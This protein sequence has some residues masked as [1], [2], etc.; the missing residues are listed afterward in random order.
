MDVISLYQSGFTNA[1]ASL[2]TA[3]TPEQAGIIKKY[4]GK[5]VLCYDADEAG[6]KAALRAGGI[7][8]EAGIKTKVL[9]ITDGKDPD[10]YIKAK[11]AE[12]F[13]NLIEKAKNLTEYRILKI[14]KEYNLEDSAEK[15]EFIT[16]VA[17]VFSAIKDPVEREIFMK[18]FSRKYDIS[19]DAVNVHIKRHTQK[20]E[21]A[22]KRRVEKTERKNFEARTGGRKSVDGMRLYNAEQLVLNLMCEKEV[23]S[24]IKEELS[25]EDF[26]EGIHRMLAE[27]IYEIHNRGERVNSAMLI[28]ELEFDD[29]AEAARILSDDKNVDNKKMAVYEPLEIIKRI[30][31]RRKEQAL[32]ED[33]D[34]DSLM[35]MM[36]QLRKDKG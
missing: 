27:K 29:T 26:S 19:L 24:V 13:K 7:L 31:N 1:V 11:G 4:K 6:Q 16:K 21:T 30:K 35:R 34:V 22:E 10:E 23:F 3:F 25:P 2:G 14:E 12:M 17:E 28:S 9:T 18:D 8:S 36:E 15:T 5:A 20:A 32:A 33:G